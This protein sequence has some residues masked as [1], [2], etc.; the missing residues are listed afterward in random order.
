MCYWGLAYSNGPNINTEV[1]E[2]MAITGRNAIKKAIDIIET[3]DIKTN[4][5]YFINDMNKEL[6]Y[7]EEKK[8]DWKNISE[9]RINTQRYYDILYNTA[10]IGSVNKYPNDVD[11]KTLYAESLL[12]LTPWDYYKK[13]V[14]NFNSSKHHPAKVLKDEINVALKTLQEVILKNPL[15]PLALHLWIH[16][17]EGGDYPGLGESKA[18]ALSTLSQSGEGTSHLLHMPA[19]IYLRIGRYNDAIKSSI[20]AINSDNL[21]MSKCLNAYVPNHNIAMLVAAAMF[22]GRYEIALQYSPYHAVDMPHDASIYLP[23]LYPSPR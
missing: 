15:H 12:N 21:Y 1:T 10:L 13:I 3:I 7:T 11:I 22:S 8:F 20:Q 19:H 9:W 18:D 14:D 17:T 5:K 2:L 16:V 23:A 6:I 4:K